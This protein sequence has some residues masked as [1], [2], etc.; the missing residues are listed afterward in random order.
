MTTA[1]DVIAAARRMLGTKEN[2]PGSN[3]TPIG[4]WY[5]LDRLP[6]C[7]MF[8]SKA[9]S[10]AGMPE[11]RYASVDIGEE[12][13]RNG[14]WGRLIPKSAQWLPGD[15]V[16]YGV[17][18]DA[19]HTGIVI[20]DEGGVITTIEGNTSSGN[21]GSQA[22]GDGVYIRNRSKADGW[23][24]HAGRPDYDKKKRRPKVQYRLTIV[25]V[26]EKIVSKKEAEAEV[27]RLRDKGLL[28]RREKVEV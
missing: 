19:Q 25:R 28:V 26:T 13:F 10:D 12:N 9:F 2:P 5:G 22:N 16:F 1:K 18:A 11:I 7:A 20:S 23:V 21:S 14:T 17:S 8:V 4:R 24:L 27:K 3:S 15:I 6:W